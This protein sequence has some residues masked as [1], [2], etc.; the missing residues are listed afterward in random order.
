MRWTYW[1]LAFAGAVV[2]GCGKED[3]PAER[4]GMSGMGGMAMD[5]SHMGGMKM[6][7]AMTGMEMMSGMRAHMD[8]MMRMPPDRMQTMMAVHD[9][10]LTRMMDGMG[11]DM[12]GMN[13]SADSSWT[14]LTDSVKQ[15]LADLPQLQGQKLAGRMR[16]HAERVQRL[17]T[18]HERMIARQA[19]QCQM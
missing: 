3:R 16:A 18:A 5:S 2:A 12:R 15:D 17:M 14:A 13:M 10:M 6:G 4:G 9:R 11:A 1:A 19:G 8:S 7:G